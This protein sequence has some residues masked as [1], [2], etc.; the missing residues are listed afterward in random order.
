MSDIKEIQLGSNVYNLKDEIC[1]R[2]KLWT[3]STEVDMLTNELYEPGDMVQCLSISGLEV[4]SLWKVQI[5]GTPDGLLIRKGVLYNFSFVYDGG[6]LNVRSLGL[7]SGGT[8]ADYAK[9]INAGYI[10]L[11]F[12]AGSYTLGELL[13]PANTEIIGEVGTTIF[14]QNH[15][16]IFRLNGNNIRLVNLRL[17]DVSPYTAHGI[18]VQ[19]ASSFTALKELYMEN[20]I[21]ENLNTGITFASTKQILWATFIKCKFIGCKNRGFQLISNSYCNLINFYDCEFAHNVNEGVYISV[22][23]QKSFNIGFYGCNIEYNGISNY[24][25]ASTAECGAYLECNFSMVNTYFESNA[26]S[27]HALTCFYNSNLYNVFFGLENACIAPQPSCS[28]SV[29]GGSQLSNKGSFL[30]STP[31]KLVVLN[32]D[33]YPNTIT[34]GV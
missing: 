34:P 3:A 15:A 23:P 21:L 17:S 18:L 33:L 27:A 2:N 30:T 22:S 19:Q 12:P 28:L 6:Y 16:N 11:F 24:G 9:L 7:G 26:P 10:K 5:N 25:V 13:L 32:S 1:R 14:S 8:N 4:P 20:V 31:S 29:I